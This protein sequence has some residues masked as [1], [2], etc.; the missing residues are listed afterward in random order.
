M[1]KSS[2]DDIIEGVEVSA[3]REMK[4][5]PD[6]RDIG[7]GFAPAGHP[8]CYPGKLNPGNGGSGIVGSGNTGE[9]AGQ[10]AGAPVDEMTHQDSQ[11]ASLIPLGQ[12]ELRPDLKQGTLEMIESL[13]TVQHQ[14]QGTMPLRKLF[15]SF[16]VQLTPQQQQDLAKRGDIQF[17]TTGETTGT[18]V[19]RGQKIKLD[20][21]DA[22]IHIPADV[23]GKYDSTG[24]NF[25]F[26]FTPGHALTACK[27][28]F[29]ADF[30][31]I[32]ADTK[33]IDVDLAGTA[34]DSCI[35]F[36][37]PGKQQETRRPE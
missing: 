24:G 10:S 2:G 33:R 17:A 3:Y 15:D 8:A 29:C 20:L 6:M 7:P 4:G 11:S 25:A 32:Q 28:I 21:E 36:E 16:G 30:E 26:H 35:V 31:N 19:N 27:F 9:S 12:C 14:G 13:Q 18:F 23:N 1:Q 37:P 34:F 22:T 5:M